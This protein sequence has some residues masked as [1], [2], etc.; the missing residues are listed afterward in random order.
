M[1]GRSNV[2][3]VWN[4]ALSAVTGRAAVSDPDERSREAEVC[5]QWYPLVRDVVQLSLIHI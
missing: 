2:L 1:A 5:R 3:D 4:A